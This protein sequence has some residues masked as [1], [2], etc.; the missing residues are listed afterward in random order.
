MLNEDNIELLI[1]DY[2]DGNLTEQDLA[3]VEY[4][5][6]TNTRWSTTYNEFMSVNSHLSSSS[7]L[8]DPSLRFTKNVMESIAA[9]QF[10]HKKKVYI[11]PFII[12]SIAAVF[13]LTISLTII[14]SLYNTNW[15]S[16]YNPISSKVTSSYDLPKFNLSGIFD[17]SLVNI[18]VCVNVILILALI[19][20]F[21]S[22]RHIHHS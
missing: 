5:I 10:I 12:R 2:I 16:T 4:H 13:M 21:M 18:I 17:G 1:W 19:D 15:N 22:K 8:S 20:S 11:N 7:L 3:D 14:Y 9:E 6:K